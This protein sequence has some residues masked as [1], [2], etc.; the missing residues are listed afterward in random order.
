M[1]RRYLVL[2][3]YQLMYFESADVCK[4]TIDLANIQHGTLPPRNGIG[5]LAP[6]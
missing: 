4:G 6:G 5:H 3:N 1:D 2:T